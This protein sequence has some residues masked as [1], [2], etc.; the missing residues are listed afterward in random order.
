MGCD[1]CKME[2]DGGFLG[3]LESERQMEGSEL[4]RGLLSLK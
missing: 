1:H 4:G 3:M 2:S